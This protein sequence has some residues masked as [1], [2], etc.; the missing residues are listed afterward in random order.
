MNIE[1]NVIIWQNSGP[2]GALSVH[3]LNVD[4]T[5]TFTYNATSSDIF[6]QIRQAGTYYL[7]NIRMYRTYEDTVFVRGYE[8]DMAYR[9]SFQGQE[10]DDEIKGKGISYDFGARIYDPRLGRFLSLDR[11]ARDFPSESSYIF[12]GNSPII[13]KDLNGDFKIKITEEAKKKRSYRD[14]NAKV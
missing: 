2:S 4:G 6:I 12:S 3:V 7:D 14:K 9:Y 13:F 10:H 8:V 11:F 5:N 1:T